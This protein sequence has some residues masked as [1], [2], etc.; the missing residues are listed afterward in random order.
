MRAQHGFPQL[1]QSEDEAS[2]EIT[3]PGNRAVLSS[4]DDEGETVATPEP[5]PGYRAE[6]PLDLSS[7]DDEGETH[8]Y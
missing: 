2:E 6:D 7:S 3:E 4:S 5:F 8:C 1:E